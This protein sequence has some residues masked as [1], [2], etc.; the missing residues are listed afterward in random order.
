MYPPPFRH[1]TAASAA[2]A[3][4]LACLL[5]SGGCGGDTSDAGSL[6]DGACQWRG[7]GVC[8]E[9]SDCPLGSD[10]A[11]CVAACAANPGAELWG[12]CRYRELGGIPSTG[13]PA[14]LA[15][16]GSN[17]KG[18]LYGWH[19]GTVYSRNPNWQQEPDH[20]VVR[21][22]YL[23]Y[24][25][26]SYDPAW[27]SPLVYYLGGFGVS[28]WGNTGFSALNT[29]AERHRIIVGDAQQHYRNMGWIGWMM[30][31][32]VYLQAF[33]GGWTDNPDVDFHRDVAHHLETLYNID[34]TR[35]YASGHSRGG[36]MS[37]ITGLVGSDVFA[38]FWAQASFVK[39]NDFKSYIL[40]TYQGRKV[41]AVIVH[42]S[43]DDNVNPG[44]GLAAAQTLE[45]AGWKKGDV[46]AGWQP[47]DQLMYYDIAGT[48][49]V[50]HRDVNEEI[51]DFLY[52]NPMP[53][54]EV[55]P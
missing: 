22:Y 52:H 25:P 44:E 53:L 11:D 42:G 46:A 31:W 41:A 37:I 48:G 24:V 8:D 40:D 39:V 5:L 12:A 32:H 55:R 17:G 28:M 43:Y 18:G 29:L 54:A 20:P 16:R 21:R 27:P 19:H 50:W 33:D 35:I 49:H 51:W 6:D 45:A 10:E 4:I 2:V 1:R 34:R 38:G 3:V 30:G 15:A 13:V 9:P 14:E 47:G 7:D 26:D 23:V 36:G